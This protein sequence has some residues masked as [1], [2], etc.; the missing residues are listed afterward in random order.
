M[1]LLCALVLVFGL[2][3]CGVA[4]VHIAFGPASI[5]GSIPVNATLDSEDRFYSSMF[6]G[7]GVALIWCSRDLAE[8]RGIFHFLLAIFFLGGVARIFSFLQMGLP[9]PLFQFLWAVELILPLVFY[10]W[11][12]FLTS[13]AS[14][15]S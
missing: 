12:R 4:L 10:F 7:F 3:C 5:P 14:D 1:R 6:F 9:H 13:Q 8:R 2:V 15:V 11:L